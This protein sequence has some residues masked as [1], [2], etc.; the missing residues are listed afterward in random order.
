MHNDEFYNTYQS[1]ISPTRLARLVKYDECCKF[2]FAIFFATVFPD[3][4]NFCVHTDALR[5]SVTVFLVYA[6]SSFERRKKLSRL[7]F[8]VTLVHNLII[9]NT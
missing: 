2:E 8:S 5:V 1:Y 6:E 9:V 4:S 3:G 7:V